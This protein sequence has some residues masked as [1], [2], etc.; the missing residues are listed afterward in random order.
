MA[1]FSD[2]YGCSL[3]L[4]ACPMWLQHRELRFSAQGYAKAMQHGATASEISEPLSACIQC[5]AC[6]LLCPAQID[7]LAMIKTCKKEAGLPKIE[8]ERFDQDCFT[9]AS[10][11]AIQQNL[12]ADDFYIIDATAFHANYAQR[13]EYYEALRQATGCSINLDLQRI[14]IPTGINHDSDTF[15]S[16]KQIEW[17]FQGRVFNRIIVENK[18]E[19]R[20]LALISGKEVIHISELIRGKNA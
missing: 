12:N 13:V 9:I 2:C 14:A 5:G 6:N 15:N 16:N 10:H 19:Q 7:L 17:L 20:H 3:C 18:K 11:A 1:S 8:T 4:L